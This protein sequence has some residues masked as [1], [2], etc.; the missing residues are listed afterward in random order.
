LNEDIENL[1]RIIK[2]QKPL[3][4]KGTKKSSI[5]I[6]ET[7]EQ[8]LSGIDI[9]LLKIPSSSAKT[10][11]DVLAFI[12]AKDEREAIS[13]MY[14]TLLLV[15]VYIN[16]VIEYGL[17]T[18][19]NGSKMN[20]EKLVSQYVES[21]FN[22]I[23]ELAQ[24][25]L[26]LA[27]IKQKHEKNI[28]PEDTINHHSEEYKKQYEGLKK[29]YDELAKRFNELS[30]KS[31]INSAKI[32]ISE[33]GTKRLKDE[34]EKL[35]VDL[36]QKKKLY[37][38]C[39]RT[40]KEKEIEISLLTEEI[41]TIKASRTSYSFP[42]IIY[43][44]GNNYADSFEGILKLELQ[45]MR[46]AFEKKIVA[47]KETISKNDEEYRMQIANKEREIDQLKENN[48]ILYRRFQHLTTK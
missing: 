42:L 14:Q 3:T 36:E 5:K 9:S 4:L 33:V 39:V 18:F 19:Y 27:S 10:I 24:E 16:R 45:T 11:E 23:T 13:V 2:T 34:I 43:S 20:G 17:I 12:G 47:L 31:S 8:Y 44:K 22:V 38:E 7:V 46:V 28:P 29:K 41:D 26:R 35:R 25:Y 37:E 30:S 32:D 6:K 40:I 21:D 1:T 15:E 48:E